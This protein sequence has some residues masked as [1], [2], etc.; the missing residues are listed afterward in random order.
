MAL[1]SSFT[2]Q[3]APGSPGSLIVLGHSPVRKRRHSSSSSGSS[4]STVKVSSRRKPP[5]NQ[6]ATQTLHGRNKGK[7]AKRRSRLT[8][9][10]NTFYVER[11]MAE[12]VGPAAEESLS[13]SSTSIKQPLERHAL[14][15]AIGTSNMP[16][17]NSEARHFCMFYI[18]SHYF[19]RVMMNALNE[20]Y[21]WIPTM[22]LGVNSLV[23]MR[24]QT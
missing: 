8:G 24:C 17:S 20:S 9:L 7:K 13:G 2:P 23:E 3:V 11:P 14:A 21:N 18:D 22:P 4:S 16:L 10:I 15:P 19:C 1:P 12:R 6:P 5:R